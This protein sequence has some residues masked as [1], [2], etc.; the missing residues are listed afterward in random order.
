MTVTV[1]GWGAKE[2]LYAGEIL[3][4]ARRHPAVPPARIQAVIAK[5]SAFDPLAVGDGGRSIG[6]GQIQIATARG[7]VKAWQRAS[8]AQIIGFLEDPAT[9]IELIAAILDQNLARA[10]GRWDA[11]HAAYNGGWS[12]RDPTDGQRIGRDTTTKWVGGRPTPAGPNDVGKYENQEYV[13]TVRAFAD[14]FAGRPLPTS[15][16]AAARAPLAVLPSAAP[17]ALAG[18]GGWLAALLGLGLLGAA[19]VWGQ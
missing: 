3:A 15:A 6:L 1:R 7:L 19:L 9:N 10:R 11:A 8:D 13:D 5:E 16:I 18:A 17:F 14:Y 2:Q 12:R 4:A